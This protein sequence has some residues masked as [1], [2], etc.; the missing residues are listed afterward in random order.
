MRVLPGVLV[1]PAIGIAIT[2]LTVF[3]MNRVGIPD[4]DYSSILLLALATIAVI[5]LTIERAP[6]SGKVVAAPL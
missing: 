1:S 3:F 2:I 4:K 6:F 5:D